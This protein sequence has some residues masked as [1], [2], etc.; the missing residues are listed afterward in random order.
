M[1]VI[2]VATDPPVIDTS[3]QYVAPARN[4]SPPTRAHRILVLDGDLG[5][6]LAVVRSLVQRH[7]VVH[8]ASASAQPISAFSKGVSGCFQYPDPLRQEQDFLAWLGA[9]QADKGYDLIIPVSERTLVPLA[10]HRP[11]FAHSRI[12]M[13]DAGS[14]AC[15][16]DKS[17][18]FKLAQSLGVRIP[19]SHYLGYLSEL[20]KLATELSYPL[21]VK[22]SR[23][24]AP[25]E[26]GYS[27]H[28]VSYA[29]SRVSL[30]A[31]CSD[32]LQHG[33]VILQSYFVGQGV[34]IE[35]IAKD[36]EILYAFQHRRL[37]ELPLTGGGSSLRVSAELEPELL[38]AATKLIRAL[39]WSG[40]AMVEFKWNPH[41][42]DYCLM[43]ING[44]LWGS[45]P[46][47]V[48]AGADFPAMLA[49]LY[50]TGALRQYP[51][52]RRGI[53]CRN[54]ASDLMWHELVLR[55][56][57]TLLA[58]VPPMPA[59]L[60]DLA[61]VL[62]A[63]HYFDT[64]T[65]RDPLP[66]LVEL[67]RL[68]ASYSA[69]L[70]GLLADKRYA[71]HQRLLWRNGTVRERVREAKTLLFVCY[72]NI[73]RSAVAAVIMAT[74]LPANCDKTVLSAG[75]HHQ[76]NRP[77]DARMVSI[78]AE[79]GV[80]LGASRSTLVSAQ[81][82][83]ASDIV[84]VMEKSHRDQLL[85]IAPEL[86]ARIFLLGPGAQPHG[87]GATD[88]PDPYNR[89]VSIYRAVFGQIQRAVTTLGDAMRIDYDG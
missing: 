47:A 7:Y 33:P 40:V 19:D 28:N 18:T 66:G 11:L 76:E 34:G 6:A 24:V 89:D 86:E 65:W 5:A 71:L 3:R 52:Y 61:L 21:V 4:C 59:I 80:D 70:I 17:A 41:T 50:L 22:P 13:A 81:L 77:A 8:V 43:E 60:R 15:V 55:T 69:R 30:D 9:H 26:S 57:S 75:F 62:S 51:A 14:L 64:Q 1:F 39:S 48:A 54:L 37:H 27:K 46:L 74:Q 44:R 49:E 25:G 36:G 31:I 88:I 35:L 63:R 42:R 32:L 83:A 82:L 38:D 53:Y 56:R 58:P 20:E 68:A 67:R 12:A 79:R 23:S 87:E 85:A 45:L 78:A 84:F 16:L 10:A 29:T 2:T 72:G 73:N